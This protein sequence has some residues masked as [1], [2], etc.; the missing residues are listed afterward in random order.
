MRI[1]YQ[2]ST[3]LKDFPSYEKAI[4]RHAQALLRPDTKISTYGVDK[5]TTESNKG[6]S[7]LWLMNENEVLDRYIQAWRE[8]YD[9]IAVGCYGDPG[10]LEAKETLDIPFMSLGETAMHFACMFGA[11]FAMI[12][13]SEKNMPWIDGHIRQ[14]G[15]QENAVP[16]VNMK[17][18]NLEELING[19]EKPEPVIEQFK[20]AA[21]KAVASGAEVLIPGCAV[22]NLILVQNGIREYK[23]AL[24]LDGVGILLKVT[25][26]LVD[27]KKISGLSVSRKLLFAS[28]PREVVD[29]AR[30]I[31]GRD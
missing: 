3:P 22:L 1:W 19:F 28:P 16:S 31:F 12:P 30:K 6:Y 18:R 25:E 9:A 13:H 15:L 27:L 5:G 2:S 10:L 23:K 20:E 24:V 29:K 26:A 21:K 11:K 4:K 17:L 7:Y 8:G 14:Y